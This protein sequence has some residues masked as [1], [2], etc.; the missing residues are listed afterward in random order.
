MHDLRRFFIKL[1]PRP[2]RRLK[3]TS[4]CLYALIYLARHTHHMRT[5]GC[6]PLLPASSDFL[7]TQAGM[8]ACVPHHVIF[9]PKNKAVPFTF[10]KSFT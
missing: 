3:Q 10:I 4:S 8:S 9:L 1:S 2:P 5:I 7:S 6:S